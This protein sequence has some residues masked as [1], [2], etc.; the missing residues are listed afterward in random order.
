I[1]LG[2]LIFYFIRAVGYSRNQEL[3][4]LS[5]VLLMVGGFAVGI[6]LSILIAFVYFF[7]ADKTIYK[8]M[9]NVISTANT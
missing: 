8:S 3:F 4:P 2:F 7:G 9:A 1:P 6:V 5:E